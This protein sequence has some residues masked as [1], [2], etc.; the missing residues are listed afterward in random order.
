MS[1][2]LFIA[3]IFMVSSHVYASELTKKNAALNQEFS[4]T[5]IYVDKNTPEYVLAE[6]IK[7]K[8]GVFYELSAENRRWLSLK[9]KDFKELKNA[10]VVNN[11]EDKIVESNLNELA[12][13]FNYNYLLFMI[14]KSN[15]R[16]IPPASSVKFII[17]DNDKI[18]LNNEPAFQLSVTDKDDNIEKGIIKKGLIFRKNS[19][20]FIIIDVD[21]DALNIEMPYKRMVFWNDEKNLIKF[22]EK[23]YPINKMNP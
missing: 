2:T 8:I 11:V 4:E 14:G 3:F 12:V 7:R 6:I 18:F 1:R 15:A 5:Y 13:F 22:I 20:A 9:I 23:N 17:Y 10:V 16:G 21:S 19:L